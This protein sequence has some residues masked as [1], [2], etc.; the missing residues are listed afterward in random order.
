[1]PTRTGWRP[2]PKSPSPECQEQSRPHPPQPGKK[3]PNL[4]NVGSSPW[5][6][7]RT[8]PTLRDGLC[9]M[10]GHWLATQEVKVQAKPVGPNR[11]PHTYQVQKE[12]ERER[13]RDR[14]ERESYV[15]IPPPSVSVP[16][17]SLRAT[18]SLHVVVDSRHLPYVH[19]SQTREC[20][21]GHNGQRKHV[22]PESLSLLRH[23]MPADERLW[24]I[25][26][27]ACLGP[28]ASGLLRSLGLFLSLSPAL[29]LFLSLS[30]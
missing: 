17:G 18:T 27:C 26:V 11:V 28:C 13:E 14:R 3:R 24:K 1:M 29:S 10:S 2:H 30:L 16:Q 15:S 12:R 23:E 5:S 20:L 21:V 8:G 6:I 19:A 7:R 25:P 9:C 4:A 22:R